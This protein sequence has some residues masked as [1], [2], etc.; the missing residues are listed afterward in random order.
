MDAEFKLPAKAAAP[1]VQF[2]DNAEHNK[3]E[4]NQA[5]QTLIN[6]GEQWS[7][8]WGNDRPLLLDIRLGPALASVNLGGL[9]LNKFSISSE[10]AVLNVNLT[11]Y[12]PQP[13]K[14]DFELEKGNLSIILPA[15]V[16][17]RIEINGHPGTIKNELAGRTRRLP[18]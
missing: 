14:G 10:R 16:P 5:N 9:P 12:W 17:S 1:Q 2:I 11:G 6:S 3:I 7:L 13:L 15:G 4:V 18:G 8:K